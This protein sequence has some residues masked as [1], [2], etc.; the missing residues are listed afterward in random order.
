MTTPTESSAS[1]PQGVGNAFVER[2]YTVL[3]KDPT[4]AYKFYLDSSELS[5]PGPD[6]AMKSVTS[7]KVSFYIYK[8]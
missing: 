8:E 7:V 5:R 1:D 4:Q 3:H 2:F 6:G